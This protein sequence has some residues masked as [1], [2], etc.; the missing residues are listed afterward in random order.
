MK[1]FRFLKNRGLEKIG[2]NLENGKI[3]TTFYIKIIVRI[4]EKISFFEFFFGMNFHDEKFKILTFK[5]F[6]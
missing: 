1:E 6:V 5:R 3:F 2:V 4:G